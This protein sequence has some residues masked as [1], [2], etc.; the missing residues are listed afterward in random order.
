M[1][2]SRMPEK[3]VNKAVED[4]AKMSLKRSAHKEISLIRLVLLAN[5]SKHCNKLQQVPFVINC[6]MHIESR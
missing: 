5:Q 6:G 3:M 2:V 1:R 4:W